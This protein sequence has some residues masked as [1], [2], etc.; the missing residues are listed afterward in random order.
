MNDGDE[1]LEAE[2]RL[3]KR[4]INA[5]GSSSPHNSLAAPAALYLTAILE[6]VSNSLLVPKYSTLLQV[7]LRVSIQSPEASQNAEPPARHVL[8]NV[9]RVASRDSSR[10][11]ATVHDLFVAL[12]EDSSMYSMFKGMKGAY[13][14]IFMTSRNFLIDVI[15]YE[16]ID[17][18]S[19]MQH[20]RRS[21]SMSKSSSGRASPASRTASPH[22][23]GRIS[24]ESSSTPSRLRV[25]SESASPSVTTLLAQ[26]ANGRVSYEKSRAKLFGRS[27]IDQESPEDIRQ[28]GDDAKSS[29]S[30]DLMV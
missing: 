2:K 15:V 10:T 5:G 6:C 1:D 28:H 13:K 26:P 14:N 29:N 9:G 8:S 3:N 20:P 19:K 18:L 4:M 24:R 16:Q 7:Y 17:S 12:C 21:K 11:V 22:G 27:S 23:D 25:S 30:F